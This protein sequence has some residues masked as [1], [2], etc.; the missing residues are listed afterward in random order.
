[1]QAPFS[2]FLKNESLVAPGDKVLLAVSGGIDSIVMCELFYRASVHFAI[3]HCNFGLREKESDE[4]ENFVEELAEKYEVP[5]HSIRFETASYAKKHKLSIQVAARELRYRWFE[6]LRAQFRYS[7]I[8]TAHHQDDSIETFFIN[9]I[10]GTGISGLHGILPKQ[11]KIIRPLLFTNKK[12]ITSFAQE[13][14]LKHR[15]D[16]SNTSEKYLRNKLRKQVIPAL[17]KMNPGIDSVLL[18]DMENLK[19]AGQVFRNEIESKRKKIVR[20]KNSTACISISGLKKLDPL[21]TYL[22]ELLKPYGFNAA[23]VA[24]IIASFGSTSGKQFFSSTHRLLKDR[25][26]LV[27]QTR[28][29]LQPERE[30]TKIKK[31][32]KKTEAGNLKLSFKEL[33]AGTFFSPSNCCASFDL[34]KLK[35]PLHIRKWQKGDT[36][37]PLGMKGRKKLS[38][39]FIDR[40]LSIAEK[41]NTW[42]LL[43]GED[44]VWVIGQRMDERFKVTGS[45][46]KI[47]FAELTE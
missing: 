46:K 21:P 37:Q 33:S 43:S 42:L 40:K 2:Q 24:E 10:R 11:G 1:M 44:I 34:D 19:A 7:S 26:D 23:T 15:E 14:K 41:E 13:H 6:E 8:A 29:A 18:K 9:L 3:A 31:K 32:Q 28:E 25:K 47:Y 5:F 45:T 12:E 17:K 38:D 16:S 39:F 30:T 20:V 4:D 27:I 22:F 36:F 35:F